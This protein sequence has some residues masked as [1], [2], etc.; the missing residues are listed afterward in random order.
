MN[1]KAPKLNLIVFVPV[2]SFRAHNLS[3]EKNVETQ[4][5]FF[6]R[7]ITETPPKYQ[8]VTSSNVPFSD[9]R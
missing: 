4:I 2:A 3:S 7:K 1:I 9:C 8:M 5:S 6:F